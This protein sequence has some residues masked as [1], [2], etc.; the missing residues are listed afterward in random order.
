[1]IGSQQHLFY[2]ITQS[3]GHFEKLED[4]PKKCDV[5]LFKHSI[6]D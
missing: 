2:K 3:N 5:Y 4:K 1:M 6:D